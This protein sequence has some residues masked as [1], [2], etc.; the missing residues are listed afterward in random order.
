MVVANR[1]GDFAVKGFAC[2]RMFYVEIYPSG[3][4]RLGEG[5]EDHV[6]DIVVTDNS[7]NL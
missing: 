4:A 6:I 3:R 2:T 7:F 5:W 1:E